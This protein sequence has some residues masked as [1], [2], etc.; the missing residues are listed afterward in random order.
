MVSEA[1]ATLHLQPALVLKGLTQGS[2]DQ[3]LASVQAAL[4][5]NSGTAAPV[6]FPAG[7]LPLGAQPQ[8]LFCHRAAL[9]K[10]PGVGATEPPSLCFPEDCSCSPLLCNAFTRQESFLWLDFVL[11]L[12]IQSDYREFGWKKHRKNWSWGI[13]VRIISNSV[14]EPHNA[15]S[16]FPF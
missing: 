1:A 9:L 10:C 8:C 16:L 13:F 6:P 12:Q 4:E 2:S 15:L 7:S 3:V 5:K 14:G 11:P